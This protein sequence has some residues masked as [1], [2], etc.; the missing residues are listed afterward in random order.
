MDANL[1]QLINLVRKGDLETVK[2][3]LS[4]HKINLNQVKQ[5]AEREVTPLMVACM[6]GHLD[7]IQLLLEKGAAVDFMGCSALMEAVVWEKVDVM[8]LLIEHGQKSNIIFKRLDRVLERV[9]ESGKLDMVRLLI[10]SGA[11][12]TNTDFLIQAVK[13]EHIDMVKLLV[14][15]GT[16]VNGMNPY[17][18]SALTVGC[19]AGKV[20]M[21]KAL[22]PKGAMS[23]PD[24][25]KF[26]SVQ[27]FALDRASGFTFGTVNNRTM[28]NTGLFD[29]Y[30]YKVSPVN[31]A[32]FHGHLELVQ[33]FLEEGVE[34][35]CGALFLSITYNVGIGITQLLLKHGADANLTGRGGWSALMQASYFGKVETVELLL[36]CGAE[37]NVQNDDGQ[38]ALLYVSKA[39]QAI[40]SSQHRGRQGRYIIETIRTQF[41]LL[42]VAKLLLEKG[43]DANLVSDNGETTSQLVSYQ[44]VMYRMP[45]SPWAQYK[46]LAYSSISYSL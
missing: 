4:S 5:T 33:W 39:M 19:E 35:P 12:V 42:E 15:E 26:D 29:S 11:H 10:K 43:A 21:V 18:E 30:S 22:L 23:M 44:G 7:V 16:K 24:S 6:N 46:T 31:I 13:A 1:Q 25:S 41:A 45:R 40:A 36:N 14:Q 8:K 28:N 3:F 27:A 37:V 32:V 38:F 17:K 9:V 2:N 20:E 34:V